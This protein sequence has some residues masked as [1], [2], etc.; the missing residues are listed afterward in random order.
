MVAIT[1][2]PNWP[3][4]ATTAAAGPFL[5]DPATLAN[6]NAW[7]AARPLILPLDAVPLPC[8]PY[9][10]CIFVYHLEKPV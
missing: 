9:L 7:H 3:R 1:S 4:L 6:P 5:S 2:A 10:V 8:R